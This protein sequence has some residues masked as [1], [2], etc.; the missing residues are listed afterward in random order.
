[1]L[2]IQMGF[3]GQEI[4]LKS[5]SPSIVYIGI[6]FN[7]KNEFTFLDPNFHNT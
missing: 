7:N 6:P 4:K 1:M 3:T 5:S 2:K